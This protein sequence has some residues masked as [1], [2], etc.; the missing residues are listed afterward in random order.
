[1]HSLM[2]ATFDVKLKCT[3]NWAVDVICILV[4]K[5]SATSIASVALM[6]RPTYDDLTGTL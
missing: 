1:M 3:D 5:K 2:I 4:V 6:Y